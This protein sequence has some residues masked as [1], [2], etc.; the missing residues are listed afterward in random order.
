MKLGLNTL[1]FSKIGDQ[2]RS[3][4]KKNTFKKKWV[5]LDYYM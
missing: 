2:I 5:S 1:N 4:E 3:E